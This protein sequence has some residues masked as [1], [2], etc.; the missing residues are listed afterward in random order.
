MTKTANNI[1]Q[2]TD[3][4]SREF[5][6]YTLLFSKTKNKKLNFTVIQREIHELHTLQHEIYDDSR[7]EKKEDLFLLYLLLLFL[8]IFKDSYILLSYFIE[9]KFKRDFF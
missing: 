2:L 8:F 4:I 6:G 7:N 3:D 9:F 5:N 1:F